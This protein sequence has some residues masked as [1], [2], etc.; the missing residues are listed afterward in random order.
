[1]SLLHSFTFRSLLKSIDF[2]VAKSVL[3]KSRTPYLSDPHVIED[4]VLA[5]SREFYDNASSGNLHQG[6]MKLAY[7]W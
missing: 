6:E 5:S 3:R 7:E 1:V 4:Q 2:H